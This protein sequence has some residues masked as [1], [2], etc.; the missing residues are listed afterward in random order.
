MP[1]RLETERVRRPYDEGSVRYEVSD[2][3]LEAAAE[4]GLGGRCSCRP[5]KSKCSLDSRL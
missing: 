2:E 3:A 1:I 4:N 5:C